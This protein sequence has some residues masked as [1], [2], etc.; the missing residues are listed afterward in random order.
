[1]FVHAHRVTPRLAFVARQRWRHIVTLAR[2]VSPEYE[3]SHGMYGALSAIY[4]IRPGI[5]D[6]VR[7]RRIVVVA[8]VDAVISKKQYGGSG[9]HAESPR[10]IPTVPIRVD[11]RDVYRS[12]GL[13]FLP[14]SPPLLLRRRRRRLRSTSPAMMIVIVSD[15]GIVE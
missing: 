3:R 8:F 11:R 15:D 5:V 2:L 6:D 1:M 10:D 7:F 12:G 9:I 4:V 13:H 14:P